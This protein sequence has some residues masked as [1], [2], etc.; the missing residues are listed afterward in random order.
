[1]HKKSAAAGSLTALW[2][3]RNSYGQLV[4]SGDFEVR[5]LAPTAA[6]P[7]ELSRSFQVRRLSR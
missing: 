5:V 7:V 3:G 4:R 1:V 6:G 2:D